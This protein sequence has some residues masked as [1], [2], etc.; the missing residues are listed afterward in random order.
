MEPRTINLDKFQLVDIDKVR[1]NT[2]N[3]KD[4]NTEEYLLLVE[5][6]KTKGQRRPIIVRENEGLEI[7]DGEQT[8]SACKE[9]G[10]TKIVVLNEGEVDDK[11]ATE[12]TFWY[13]HH[14]P[15]NEAKK[16]EI[17]TRLIEKYQTVELPFNTNKLEEMKEL[18][19]FGWDHYKKNDK[20]TNVNTEN[21]EKMVTFAV[22]VKQDQI[23]VINRAIDLIKQEEG[24]MSEGRALELICA[25]YLADAGVDQ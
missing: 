25:D 12:M 9:L 23:Q 17:V 20:E 13:Q 14:V 18:V 24:D 16:A 4:K 19:K 11:E 6:I 22:R 1:P 7:I 15:F 8:W 3:P 21:I 2:W 5:G 10:Y